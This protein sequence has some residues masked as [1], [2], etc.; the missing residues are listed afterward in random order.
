M[1]RTVDFSNIFSEFPEELRIGLEEQYSKLKYA[2]FEKKFEPT[3]LN[4]SKLCEIIFRILEWNTAETYTPLGKPIFN[5][6]KALKKFENLSEF[7]DSVRFHIPKLLIF[8]Y[9]IRNKRG[10][11]HVSNE[12]NPNY[13]DSTIIVAS[14][15][16]VIAELIRL[17]NKVEL[18][19]AK[20]I[21]EQIIEKKL[22]F[23]WEIQGKKRILASGLGYK[24]KTLLLL[25]SLQTNSALG[26]ELSDWV[27]Y[28]NQT[29]FTR[30]ILEQLHK[31]KM[32]EYSKSN[33]LAI[34]SPK[35]ILEIEQTIFPK[36]Y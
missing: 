26:K 16:W 10:V 36:I 31:E 2:F 8:I 24:E 30:T 5:F 14:C 6:D 25:Y 1:S 7:P 28:S 23:V 12:I 20:I 18:E 22:P 21:L 32:I 27:E 9:S 19:D 15:D 3:E 33:D 13:M 11:A 4:A 17:F 34:L 29:I 35:G